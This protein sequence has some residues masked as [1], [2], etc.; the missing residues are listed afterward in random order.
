M[1]WFDKARPDET[2]DALAAIEEALMADEALR[3]EG[4]KPLGFAEANWI[5]TTVLRALDADGWTITR[6]ARP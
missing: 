2:P 6:E 1:N 5:G 4:G 3:S